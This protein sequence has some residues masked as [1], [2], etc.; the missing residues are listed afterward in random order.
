[1]PAVGSGTT[2]DSGI[3]FQ[4]DSDQY[5]SPWNAWIDQVSFTIW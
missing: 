1:M 3:Q 2:D 5:G 4:Q